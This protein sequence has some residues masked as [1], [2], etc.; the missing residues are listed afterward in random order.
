M[1][2]ILISE[3]DLTLLIVMA[4][5]ILLGVVIF[6]LS[7]VVFN[8][9]DTVYIMERLGIYAG[10]FNVRVKYF[11]PLLYR[12][13]GVYKKGSYK[14]EIYIG[15]DKY[16]LEYRISNYETF[17]YS[18]HDISKLIDEL[19]NVEDKKTHLSNSLNKVGVNLI[20]FYKV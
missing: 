1:H 7:G 19:V 12:R 10:T 13:V 20:N 16:Y 5:A 2:M 3:F 4:I 17:H 14:E 11:F 6:F 18:G 9:S 8:K 15:K